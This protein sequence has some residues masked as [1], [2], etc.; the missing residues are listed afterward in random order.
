MNHHPNWKNTYN[1]V[2]I[3]LITNDVGG[4]SSKDFDLAKLIDSMYLEKW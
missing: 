2:S 3:S 1:K 4:L